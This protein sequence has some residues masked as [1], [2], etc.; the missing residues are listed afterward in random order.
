MDLSKLVR[1]DEGLVN[2]KIFTDDDIY[3]QELKNIFARCW[4][5]LGHVSQLKQPGDFF[6]TYMGAD[7]VIVTRAADDRIRCFLNSCTHR[8]M[9]VCRTDHGNQ[10]DFTCP[11]HGWC[12]GNDGSLIG[13]PGMRPAYYNELDKSRWGLREVP[14][15]ATFRG[16]IFATWD[17]KVP[18]LEDY[19]GDMAVYLDRMVNRMDGG[20]EM[21]GGI[22]KWEISV[23]WKLIAENFLGDSYHVTS[24][25][26]SV[27]DI[28]FRKRP[29]MDG[30]QITAGGGHGFGSEE[31]GIGDGDTTSSDYS[32]FVRK[33]RDNMDRTASPA[34]R[35]IPIGHGTIFPNLSFLD[36]V[37]FRLIRI[38]HPRGPWLTESQ[39]MCF[40]D[41]GLPEELRQSIR[42][43]FILSFGPSGMFEVEDGEIWSEVTDCLR[44]YINQQQDF[45]YQ[46]GLHHDK[47]VREKFD[48]DLPGRTGWYWSELNHRE[49][50]RQ[51]LA[52]MED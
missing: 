27:V 20:I 8:G 31:G 52:L 51:W 32:A 4:L 38:S 35:F 13:V 40:V 36:N 30:Y 47:S 21:I 24:T 12:F 2:R 23:N 42:R 15:L 11:Y 48:L 29:K 37:K 16:M 5:Y 44:G 6:T 19:L 17:P 50:Y 22:Q 45:N 41:A 39:T 34:D 49:Y 26:G 14:G 18:S 1:P 10:S 25:H 7:S 33:L 9:K 3:Q 28:G 43:D 46:M